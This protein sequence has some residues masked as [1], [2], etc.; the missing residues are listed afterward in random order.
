[1]TKKTTDNMDSVIIETVKGQEFTV[2]EIKNSN[3][4]QKS[5][6]PKQDL[7]WYIKWTASCF[8]LASMSI[9]GIPDLATWDIS[10]SL[11]GVTGWMWVGF[12]WKDRALI[13][14]NGVGILLFART[15]LQDY[16]LV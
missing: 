1:M 9:R 16:F 7:S 5:A 15:L 2:G 14:L 13:L 6:T 11:I 8:I 3:R 4:I 10:L 12:L